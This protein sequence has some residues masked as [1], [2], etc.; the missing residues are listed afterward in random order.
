MKSFIIV[1]TFFIIILLGGVHPTQAMDKSK[2]ITTAQKILLAG[3]KIGLDEAGTRLL[4]PTAWKYFKVILQPIIDELKTQYPAL[5]FDAPSSK[6]AVEAAKQAVDELSTDTQLH[7]LLINNFNKLTDGQITI[8]NGIEE[9]DTKLARIEGG[10][11]IIIEIL[12]GDQTYQ[13]GSLP[14]YVDVSDFTDNVAAF[15]LTKN[16]SGASV[17]PIVAWS[18]GSNHFMSIVMEYGKSFMTYETQ[19]VISGVT[20]EESITPSGYYEIDKYKCRDYSGK[21]TN[22]FPGYDAEI[23]NYFRKSCFVNGRWRTENY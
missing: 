23:K 12:R 15:L 8:I 5:S 7:E 3:V 11:E 6:E 20:F 18:L 22:K 1:T 17:M 19:V 14:Q 16:P 2:L 21:S 4:G 9:L 13:P 10:I